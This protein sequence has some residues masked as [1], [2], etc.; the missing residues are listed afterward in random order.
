MTAPA[1]A[2]TNIYGT[3][4][5]IGGSTLDADPSMRLVTGRALLSQNL[6]C[7]FSTP[8]GSVIDC[9]NDCLDLRDEVSDGLTSS[10]LNAL[11]GKIQQEALKDQRVKT[12]AVTTSFNYSTST[13]TVTMNVTSLY[14]PFALVLS[15]SALTV[16]ILDANLPTSSLTGTT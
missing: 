6:V 7:R 12:V 9:P 1:N 13:L 10:E 11:R 16:T 4:F 3:D 8:R 15:V 14:G 5:W 2:V